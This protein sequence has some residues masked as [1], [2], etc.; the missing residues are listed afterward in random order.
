M[1]DRVSISFKD[2]FGESVVLFSHFGGM[3]LVETARKYGVDLKKRAKEY[4]GKPLGRMDS[5]TVIVDFIRFLTKDM[6]IVTGDF[7]LGATPD[8]ADNSDNGHHV[9]ELNVGNS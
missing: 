8:D 6:N 4:K 2:E 3:K 9:I 7:S 5:Q 1:G